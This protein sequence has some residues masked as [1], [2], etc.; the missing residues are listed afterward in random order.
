MPSVKN[1]TAT[2][3]TTDN[4]ARCT[5]NAASSGSRKMLQA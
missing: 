1:I 3:N 2:E 4:S 5:L